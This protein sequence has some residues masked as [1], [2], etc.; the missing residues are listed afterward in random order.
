M[1]MC[2]CVFLS[3]YLSTA[4]LELEPSS[5]VLQSLGSLQTSP[6]CKT[7][8]EPA[9]RHFKEDSG[10]DSMTGGMIA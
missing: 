6:F 8:M 5:R 3:P 2:F 9:T 7:N 1:F 10:Q 4:H